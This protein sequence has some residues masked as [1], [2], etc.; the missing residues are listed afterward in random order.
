[1]S[2]LFSAF[3]VAHGL[4][5]VVMW[6]PPTATDAPFDVHASPVFGEVRVVSTVGALVAGGLLVV[7]GIA[8]APGAGWWWVPGTAGA[9]LSA[10][11]MLLTFS[12]WWVFGL[13][14]DAAIVWFAVAS[15]S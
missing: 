13:A 3:L 1:M 12:P 5:H 6:A 7:A 9:L 11:V 15:R 8:Y 2:W 14:I 4:V 10:A